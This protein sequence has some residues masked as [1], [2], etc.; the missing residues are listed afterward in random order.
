M[1]R[2]GRQGRKAY[3]PLRC[4]E[5]GAGGQLARPILFT[6]E[7]QRAQRGRA[8][9]SSVQTEHMAQAGDLIGR[10]YTELSVGTWEYYAAQWAQGTESVFWTEVQ[11][12]WRGRATGTPDSIHYRGTEITERA[13]SRLGRTDSTY[14]AGGRPDRSPL[15]RIERVGLGILCSAMGAESADRASCRLGLSTPPPA[16]LEGQCLRDPTLWGGVTCHRSRLVFIANM[17]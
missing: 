17:G 13:G 7:A 6:T 8:A 1:Q 4:R 5:R 10:P 11:S 12:A 16:P 14:G 2:N 3:S 9:G 15:H